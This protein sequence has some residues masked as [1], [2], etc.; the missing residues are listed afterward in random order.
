LGDNVRR[1]PVTGKET[2]L[3]AISQI[4]GLS[5]VS[6]KNIWIARPLAADPAKAKILHVDWEGITGRGATATNYQIFPGDRV[7]IGED[8]LIT[9]TNL[10]AKKTAPIERIMGIMGLTSST[11]SGLSGASVDDEVLKELVRKG[12]FTDD[13]EMKGILQELIR[14]RALN[15]ENA[16][17]KEAAERK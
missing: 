12:V 10:L 7:F 8:P 13:A 11:L 3:D 15:R 4:N 1:L 9:R 16:P 6:S 17:S 14:L 5:Q 2:V